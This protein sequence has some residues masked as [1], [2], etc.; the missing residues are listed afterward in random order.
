M[1]NVSF[2]SNVIDWS[3]KHWWSGISK[4][5]SWYGFVRFSVALKIDIR[6]DNLSIQFT[7]MAPHQSNEQQTAAVIT[8]NLRIHWWNWKEKRKTYDFSWYQWDYFFNLFDGNSLEPRVHYSI[9]RIHYNTIN[10]DQNK[11]WFRTI[12]AFENLTNKIGDFKNLHVF[13][14]TTENQIGIK[15]ESLWYESVYVYF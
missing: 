6:L 12:F 10:K 1:V 14:R 5:T 7:S 8:Q 4:T 11:R 13:C 9:P 2:S 3:M 15:N